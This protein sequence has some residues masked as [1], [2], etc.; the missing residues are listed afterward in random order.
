MCAEQSCT[1]LSRLHLAQSQ[2]VLGLLCSVSGP[3]SGRLHGHSLSGAPPEHGGACMGVGLCGR[4][5]WLLALLAARVELRAWA[6]DALPRCLP[7]KGRG[8]PDLPTCLQVGAGLSSC[9]ALL[10]G[11]AVVDHRDLNRPA[12]RCAAG[13]D[14]VP[15]RL[16]G[17]QRAV[18]QR[19]AVLL[20][21]PVPLL[22]GL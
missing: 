5:L 22:A 21:G 16:Q 13:E 14:R 2:E 11:Q 20:V 1:A 18:L 17:R 4:V 10:A 12:V 7:L 15:P 8:A 9:P 6:Q 19:P 3:I